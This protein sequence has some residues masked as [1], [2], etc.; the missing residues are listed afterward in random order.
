MS[1]SGADRGNAGVHKTTEISEAVVKLKQ[2]YL[3][4]YREAVKVMYNTGKD[5]LVK[6]YFRFKIPYETW[7]VEDDEKQRNVI[8]KKNLV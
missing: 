2:R 6:N 5:M 7:L 1:K 8:N 3:S 4:I